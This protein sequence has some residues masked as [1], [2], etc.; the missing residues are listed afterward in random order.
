MNSQQAQRVNWHLAKHRTVAIPILK[1][2]LTAVGLIFFMG[3]WNDFFW[4]LVVLKRVEHYT[5]PVALASLHGLA[6]GVIPYGVVLAGATIGAL[7]LAILF[8]AL[9]RW[10]VSGILAGALKG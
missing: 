10:F 9:Q 1:P 6:Y 5:V 8:L 3:N 4:P 7:P 2:A